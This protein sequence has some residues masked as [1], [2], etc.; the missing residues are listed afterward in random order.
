MK[1]MIIITVCI[2]AL[3]RVIVAMA[4]DNTIDQGFL[5]KKAFQYGTLISSSELKFS[6]DGTYTYEYG[7]E[8]VSWYNKGTYSIKGDSVLLKPD[9]CSTHKEGTAGDCGETM[10]EAYCSI[11]TMPD[12]LYYYK[13]FTC[14]SKKNKNAVTTNDASMPFPVEQSKVKAGTSKVYKGVPVVAMG[15]AKGVTT[16]NVKIREKPSVNAKSLEYYKEIYGPG[17]E[18]QSVPANTEVVVIARTRERDKVQSWNNYWYL[19]S[20]GFNSEVWMFGEFV[21]IK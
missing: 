5:T 9:F 21:K 16:T 17:G 6:P 15:L 1:K 2:P 14:T 7:S 10:G 20:V 8:G 13:Y 4:G 12:D 18:F 3:L 11:R 19:V